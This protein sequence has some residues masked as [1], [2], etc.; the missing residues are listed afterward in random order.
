MQTA[1]SVPSELCTVTFEVPSMSMHVTA[2]DLIGKVKMSTSR[3]SIC[4][5]AYLYVDK[6][7]IVYTSAQRRWQSGACLLS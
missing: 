2:M 6:L 3:P 7:H 4:F 1:E 5:D